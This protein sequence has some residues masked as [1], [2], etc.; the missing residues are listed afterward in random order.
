MANSSHFRA[1]SS[2]SRNQMTTSNT[3]VFVTPK[4]R[5][6]LIAMGIMLIASCASTPNNPMPDFSSVE[7]KLAELRENPETN[8]ELLTRAEN[9]IQTAQRLWTQKDYAESEH[10]FY[11]S[12]KATQSLQNDIEL[13]ALTERR[14]ALTAERDQ[15]IE[16]LHSS[17]KVNETPASSNAT[18]NHPETSQLPSTKEQLWGYLVNNNARGTVIT[19]YDLD[20]AP[21]HGELAPSSLKRLAPLLAYLDERPYRRILIEGHLS[22]HQDE[23]KNRTL[24]TIHAQAVKQAFVKHGLEAHR[25]EARGFGSE[26]P[27]ASARSEQS[28]QLNQRVE[29]VIEAPLASR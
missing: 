9:H 7:L 2:H 12:E 13:K 27:I 5:L 11:L 19:L 17:M 26:V 25:I 29:I 16:Q 10:Q 23:S 22:N 18:F 20:Y 15:I 4:H 3:M 8:A 6:A 24:S 14:T 21:E 1:S 28:K